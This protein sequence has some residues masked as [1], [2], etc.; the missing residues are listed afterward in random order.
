LRSANSAAAGATGQP[1]L[2]R[3]CFFLVLVVWCR[4]VMLAMGPMLLLSGLGLAF[5]AVAYLWLKVEQHAGAGSFL[6]RWVPSAVVLA[7][8]WLTYVTCEPFLEIATWRI[9][10]AIR[11]PEP[12]DPSVRYMSLYTREDL[13]D[14]DP[15]RLIQP[16]K[17]TGAELIVGN[18]AMYSNLDFVTGYSPT[19]PAGMEQVLPFRMQGYAS[20]KGIERLLASETGPH[21]LL[22]LLGVDGLVVAERFEECRPV[23]FANGWREVAAVQGG[24]VFHRIGQRSAHVRA[25]QVAQ[26]IGDRNEIQERITMRTD[27]PAP[28]LV[29]GPPGSPSTG[30]EHFVTV[31]I[32][33]IEERRNSVAVELGASAEGEG[34]LVFSRPWFPGYRATLDGKPLPV[35]VVNLML[36]AVRIPPGAQGRLVLEYLPRSLVI[37]TWC[38]STTA[39]LIIATIALA[40]ILSRRRTLDAEAHGLQGHDKNRD[41]VAAAGPA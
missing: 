29:L 5:L 16:S 26:T 23:L 7:T 12:F 14:N 15:T 41:L 27:G 2:G 28:L 35:E 6:R 10:E 3:W 1:S 9:S 38:S 19:G 33:N 25:A 40:C 39:I 20:A 36:P 18:T 4:A 34:L 30:D 11:H 32:R 8:C 22:E 31:E 13:W 17:G 24:M 21:G 37:G